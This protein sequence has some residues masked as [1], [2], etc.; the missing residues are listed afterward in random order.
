MM[1]SG[2][3]LVSSH[4]CITEFGICMTKVNTPLM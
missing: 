4:G 2:M 1:A 3:H